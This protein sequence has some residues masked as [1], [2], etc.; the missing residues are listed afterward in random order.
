MAFAFTRDDVPADDHTWLGSKHAVGDARTVTLDGAA[1]TALVTNGYIPSGIALAEGA[2]GLFTPAT[3]ATAVDGIL[4]TQ[5]KYREGNLVAPMLW[6][7]SVIADNAPEQSI[8]L[9]DITNPAI[10]VIGAKTDDIG[11]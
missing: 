3:D 5:Q 10:T 2:D 11:D 9:A 6:H 4:L 1:F 7:C 8:N